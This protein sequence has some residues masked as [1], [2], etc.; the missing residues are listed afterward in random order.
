[1]DPDKSQKKE[2]VGMFCMLMYTQ[3]LYIKATNISFQDLPLKYQA[4]YTRSYMLIKLTVSRGVL[5]V[6]QHISGLQANKTCREFTHEYHCWTN[7]S[8]AITFPKVI[9]CFHAPPCPYLAA[10]LLFSV[11]PTSQWALT[12][13]LNNSDSSSTGL[14]E[15]HLAP[16]GNNTS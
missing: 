1:M 6:Y 8:V 5:Q 15:A 9:P 3:W 2:S 4:C 16:A 13:C 11:F 12:A 10:L 7:A 14:C